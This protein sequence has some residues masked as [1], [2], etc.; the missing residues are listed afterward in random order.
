[1]GWGQ[2]HWAIIL[3]HLIAHRGLVTPQL[4][5]R[6]AIE[7]KPTFSLQQVEAQMADLDAM[8]VRAA[9]FDLLARGRLRCPSIVSE[10]L[11]PATQLVRP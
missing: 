3:Q 10:S 4:L 5:E 2:D 6:C 7:L 8:L 11:N 1:V 9:V